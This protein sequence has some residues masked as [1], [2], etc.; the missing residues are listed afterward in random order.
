MPPPTV[1]GTSSE[2]AARS[3][4]SSGGRAVLDRRRHVEEDDLVGPERRVALGQLDRVADVPEVLEAD[5]LDHAAAGDVEAGDQAL[6]DHLIAFVS[7]RAPA[8]SL[9]SGWNWTPAS[10]PR[11]TAA[12]TG[13]S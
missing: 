9:R 3:T 13:P 7:T 10:A 4:S 11:S 2:A 12:T 1:N 8:R 6:L 5:A